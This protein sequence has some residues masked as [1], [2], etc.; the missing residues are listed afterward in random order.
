MS[1]EAIAWSQVIMAAGTVIFVLIGLVLGIAAF[2]LLRAL[3]RLVRTLEKQVETLTPRAD[4]LIERATQ[5]ADDATK[6]SATLRE[7]LGRVRERVDE[8]DQ[9]FQSAMDDVEARARRFGAVMTVVQEEVEDILLDATATARGVHVTAE[10]L[11]KRPVDP[12]RPAQGTNGEGPA[13]PGS[14][15]PDEGPSSGG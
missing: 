3:Q 12:P 8:L 14:P 11:G 10:A 4:P 15:D 9:R 5:L 6:I 13:L 2:L 7:D 1:L